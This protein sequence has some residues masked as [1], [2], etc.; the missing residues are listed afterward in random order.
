MIFHIFLIALVLG[1]ISVIRYNYRPKGYPP[2][3][4]SY[5]P[6][7]GSIVPF[8]IDFLGFMRSGTKKYGNLWTTKLMGHRVTVVGHRDLHDTFFKPRNDILNPS[9]VYKFMKPVFGPGVV[10][11]APHHI[12]R[13]QLGFVAEQL[14]QAKLKTCIPIIQQEVRECLARDWGDEGEINLLDAMASMLISTAT[15]C[16][17]GRHVKDIITPS[18][19]AELL[20]K[21]EEGINP[22]AVF[23]HW[24]PSIGLFKQQAARREFAA[25]A[26]AILEERR[27]DPK[28]DEKDDIIT[29]LLDAVYR[30]GTEMTEDEKVGIMLG[31]TFAGQHT[32]LIT[33]TW[34]LL[35]LSSKDHVAKLKRHRT[36]MET[37]ADENGELDWEGLNEMQFTDSVFKEVLRLHPPLIMLMRKVLQPIECGGYTI[38]AGDTLA[39]SALASHRCDDVYKHADEFNPARFCDGGEGA[40]TPWDFIGFGGGAHRC[41]GERFGTLQSKTVFSTILHDYDI[42]ILNGKV[43]EPDY[44]TMVVGPTRS[45]SMIRYKKKKKC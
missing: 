38:P 33:S 43:P 4:P 5:V 15:L 28:A 11:D 9:E 44:T 32:S 34:S 13:Q 24:L 25:I 29:A 6:F 19:L 37:Y 40:S 41:L 42:E 39:V 10:Y 7:I 31:V 17:F 35:Y 30:D 16:L 18:K 23:I 2:I 36:E 12:M 27:N 26:S 21:I 20:C 45:Q 3:R 14:S 22:V 8:G 1:V